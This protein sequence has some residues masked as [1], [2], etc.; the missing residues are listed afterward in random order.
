MEKNEN[1]L[2]VI[3]TLFKYKKL[4]L[5]TCGAVFIGS[6]IISLLL[7][8]YYKST[9]TFYAASPDFTNPD[10]MFGGSNTDF[11]YYGESEDVERL[12]TIATSGELVNYMIDEF[13]LYE[14]YDMDST[15][16][17]SAFYI[18]EKFNGLYSVQKTKYDAIEVSIEDKDR[19]LAAKMANAARQ[20][21]EDIN[22][23]LAREGQRQQI[24]AVKSSIANE[25]K[26]LQFLSDT[27]MKLKAKYSIFDVE[28]QGETVSSLYASATSNLSKVEGKYQALKSN[29]G[30]PR[31]SILKAKIQ[32]EASRRQ[33]EAMK[34]DVNLF[35]E[36]S[37]IVMILSEQ[38]ESARKQLS[39]D[40]ER[41]KK[42]EAA[43]KSDA[44]IVHLVES[45]QI[46]LVKSKPVRFIIVLASTA[47]AFLMTIL[48]LL[49]F[50]NYRDVNWKEI[51]N[52]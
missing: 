21:I 7:P 27:L 19:E 4:I 6:V 51:I 15:G 49:I 46:P 13:N 30:M 22:L 3:K 33:V 43:S 40:I 2:G 34:K 1:I 5:W 28:T 42:I 48:G 16:A 44:P 32:L 39:W 36:G 50:D 31:D 17:K 25:K 47:I 35:N 38:H 26:E 37:S 24:E 52:G 14:H 29:P 12:L 9:T 45:A 23:S 10:K 18:A 8:V 11:K 20:K 41:A